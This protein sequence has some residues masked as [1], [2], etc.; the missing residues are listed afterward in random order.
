MYNVE[1]KSPKVFLQKTY[2]TR[3]GDGAVTRDEFVDGWVAL[4]KQTRAEANA[5]F[6]VGDLNHDKVIDQKDHDMMYTVFDQNVM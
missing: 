3:A 4:T 1:K 6:H 2:N 5:Y